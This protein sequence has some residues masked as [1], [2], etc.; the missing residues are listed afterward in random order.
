MKKVFMLFIISA[1]AIGLVGCSA[2]VSQEEYDALVEENKRLQD[3][4]DEATEQLKEYIDE[5]Q[6][7]IVDNAS[8]IGY[9]AVA[10][11][12]KDDA[13]CSAINEDTV[14]ITVPLEEGESILDFESSLNTA[15][16]SLGAILDED[17]FSSCII[18][19][20]DFDG[21]CSGGFSFVS[22]GEVNYFEGID[23]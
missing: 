18:M 15:A 12:I 14:L 19:F 21:K 8:L 11:V 1:F 13:L 5:E 20:V 9:Q 4:F 22:N 10:S 2:G 16:Y 17:S 23:I 6:K 3:G 7:E